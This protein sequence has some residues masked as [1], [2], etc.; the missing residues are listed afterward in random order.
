M[1]S[2][3]ETG[4][5]GARDGLSGFS[6]FPRRLPPGKRIR[7][8]RGKRLLLDVIGEVLADFRPPASI[9]KMSYKPGAPSLRP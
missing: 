9:A 3:P 1:S 8:D 5:P 7:V 4:S 6:G 2:P